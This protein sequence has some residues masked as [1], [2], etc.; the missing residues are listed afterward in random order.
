[1][2]SFVNLFKSQ[3]C[4]GYQ[5]AVLYLS[6][7]PL[8]YMSVEKLT[9]R[10]Q[11]GE[12]NSPRKATN[13][14]KGVF[15]SKTRYYIV[16]RPNYKRAKASY[17]LKLKVHAEVTLMDSFETLLQAHNSS[18]LLECRS[19]VL[20]SWLLPCIPCT[21]YIIKALQPFI[22]ERKYEIVVI[23]IQHCGRARVRI[24]IRLPR[25]RLRSRI[26]YIN[27]LKKLE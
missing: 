4:S 23:Y 22:S 24:K 15:P 20:Y 26:K 6:P 18:S 9:F 16:A 2:Q 12:V 5:F 8:R 27:F 14:R 11:E 10:T 21:K 19:I 13:W 7:L 1:M 3:R 17:R 25:K